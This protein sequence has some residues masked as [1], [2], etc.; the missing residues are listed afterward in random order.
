RLLRLLPGEFDDPVEC[1][2]ITYE[3][4]KAPDYEPISYAWG[5][6]TDTC[7]IICNRLPHFITINLFQALR[8]F[9]RMQPRLLW[10]D[11]I[12]IDQK[13]NLE[14]NHQVAFMKE[15]YEHGYRTLVWLGEE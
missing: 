10:A 7:E 13:S 9:R 2:L 5:D 4:N 3:L 11:N 6:L 14:K 12:C 15:I 1:Q 8:R